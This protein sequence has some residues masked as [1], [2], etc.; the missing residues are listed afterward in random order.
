MTHYV[1][2]LEQATGDKKLHLQASIVSSHHDGFVARRQVDRLNKQVGYGK[3][4]FATLESHEA[5]VKG[6][7]YPELVAQ[8]H[9]QQFD[10]KA[11]RVMKDM[12]DPGWGGG[13]IRSNEDIGIY[14]AD[15]GLTLEQLRARYGEQAL[16]ELDDARQSKVESAERHAQAMATTAALDA[17]HCDI[18]YTFP[19]VRGM[20]AGRAYY[21]AQIPYAVL[22]KL[23]TFDD[24]DQVPAALRAQRAL[25]MRRAE[26][27]A[28]YMV[29]NRS[30]YVLPAL[31]ASVSAEMRFEAIALP[32]AAGN[33]GILHVPLAAVLLINDGQHRR[34]GIELALGRK[35]AL[36]DETIAVT[37]FYD[38][39]L[40]RS[41]QMFAD[42]NGKQVKPSS[43]I[44]TLYDRRNPYNAW[45][46]SLLDQ[47]PEIGQ[48]V[49]CE[50]ASVGAKSYKLWSLITIKKFFG[51]LTGVTEKNVDQISVEQLV[52]IDK[53]V[54]RFFEE[55]AFMIPQWQAM[56][57]NKLSAFD[58][59]ESLVIGHAVFL[60]AL[61]IFGRHAL[62]A[63]QE[64]KGADG[65]IDP[66]KAD[67]NRV[68]ALA[69][70][71]PAKGAAMWAGRCVVLGKMQK[72][73]DGV[74][75]TAAQLL[76]LGNLPLDGAMQ[77]LETRLAA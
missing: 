65:L 67:W 37:I 40:L 35:P 55:S 36:R 1:I 46:L 33:V 6:T 63:G 20:Q 59:R 27:I 72:T 39:G 48:R 54:A 56:I 70:I 38:Q 9:R 71:V 22:V 58:V 24:E 29:G 28:T 18:S 45:V 61:A 15:L 10:K 42:I 23:F 4:C 32:G 62:F 60:E 51:L 41:Q 52:A 21:A 31:T 16:R 66:D 3:P 30:D 64:V 26:D 76:K 13:R 74:K 68:S 44:N 75:S 11:L 25:N 73:V 7:Q 14:L 17:Q 77:A 5:L 57:D 34:K 50:N 49:D 19:A 8:W 2:A 47:L 12:V 53:F 43:A 69:N